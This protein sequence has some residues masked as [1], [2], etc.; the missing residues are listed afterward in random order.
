MIDLVKLQCPVNMN[1]TVSKD[2]NDGLFE[3][4]LPVMRPA[5]G[6]QTDMNLGGAVLQVLQA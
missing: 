3:G 5:A 2:I 1:F 6:Y 4:R